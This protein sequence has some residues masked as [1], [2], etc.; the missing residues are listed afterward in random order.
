[1][2]LRFAIFMGLISLL[3]VA[4]MVVPGDT[5]AQ[6]NSCPVLVQQALEQ[7]GDNCSGLGRNNAC[8]GYTRVDSSFVTVST[9]DFFNQP[10]DR[11]ALADLQTISTQPLDLDLNQ[12][13]IALLNVQANV[14]NALPGQAV[15][16][17]L[18]GDTEV[19]N[20]VDPAD[21]FEPADPVDVTLAQAAQVFTGPA[22]NTNVL[23]LV[24][25]GN[26]LPADGLNAD[27]LRVFTE[28]GL[29]WIPVDAIGAGA[30]VSD[31]PVIPE[32][33]QTPMQSFQVR[34]AFNDLD[35]N[36]APSVLAIQS[37]ENIKVDL[38]ANGVHIRLGSLIIV[39]TLPPGDIMQVITI[40]GDVVLDPET[41]LET[42]VLPGFKTQRCLAD[43]GN[44]SPD[45]EWS[46]PEPLSADELVFTQTVLLAYQQVDFMTGPLIVDGETITLIDTDA[47][48]AGMQLQ[49]TVSAG[50]S[51]SVIALAYG[52]SVDALVFGNN[53]TST[54]ILPGQTLDVICGARTPTS[55]PALGAPPVVVPQNVVPAGP[56]CSGFAATSP[57]DGL[58]YGQT[59]FYWDAPNFTPD[60]YRVTVTGE[61]GSASFTTDGSNTN[62]TAD[63]TVNTVGFGFSFSWVVEALVDGDVACSSASGTMFREAP[64]APPDDDDDGPEPTPARTVEPEYCDFEECYVCEGEFCYCIC[65]CC[66]E[67]GIDQAI[68]SGL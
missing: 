18:M 44:V 1:M 51:L 63:I 33:P 12:W 49:H 21:A 68:S 19:T 41:D 4:L 15:V 61:S 38:N 34:T 58:P 26:T 67:G 20:T 53:L 56:D 59:T 9:E 2:R 54:V 52:T 43:D 50:E 32:N 39:R 23:T 5:V 66:Q 11:A 17:M 3:L 40:E 31:L 14:P 48:P 37:P 7:M 64:P 27:W 55:L 16:F 57:L 10:A 28:R 45:C 30:D 13:G 29:G 60:S 22:N 65:E 47:C 35:C 62:L 42:Q 36:E 46:T 25:A 6:G 8:Y 24:T